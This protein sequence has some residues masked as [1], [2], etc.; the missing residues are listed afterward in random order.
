MRAESQLSA[1][2]AA[3]LLALLP[4][5]PRRRRPLG[6]TPERVALAWLRRAAEA[7]VVALLS[8]LLLFH[9]AFLAPEATPSTEATPATSAAPALS[10]AQAWDVAWAD[11]VEP[12]VAVQG[13]GY[14]DLPVPVLVAVLGSLHSTFA[15]VT[16]VETILAAAR[17]AGIDPLLLFACIGAEQ[18]WNLQAAYPTLWR[19]YARNPFD[20]AIYGTWHATDYTLAESAAIAARTLAARLSIPPPADEPA[21]AWI[22]D[23]H[24]HAGAGVYATD[25]H[26]WSNVASI[27]EMLTRQ[28]VAQ[29]GGALGA[30]TL[31]ALGVFALAVATTPA[32]VAHALALRAQGTGPLAWAARQVAYLRQYVYQHAYTLAASALAAGAGALGIAAAPGV[33]DGLAAAAAT[34]IADIAAAAGAAVGAAAAA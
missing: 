8:L 24:N 12:P 25:P 18:P 16:D 26:W 31:Q 28:V 32:A 27:A 34:V 17:A 20:I 11:L 3:L 21:L 2:E 23:P 4:P 33:I 1:D 13:F 19:A 15:D 6:N 29:A 7:A 10:P 30:D 22:E 14:V 9:I 5:P